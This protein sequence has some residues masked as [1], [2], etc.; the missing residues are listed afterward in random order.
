[1]KTLK[2]ILYLIALFVVIVIAIGVPTMLIQF[3]VAA[4]GIN[5]AEDSLYEISGSGGIAAAAV[6]C[7]VYVKK[8]HSSKIPKADN[9]NVGNALIFMLFTVFFCKITVEE[10]TA[11]LLCGI[12]P[13]ETFSSR[14]TY[15]LDYIFAILFAPIFEELL[16][17]ACS[18]KA[19]VRIF[20]HNFAVF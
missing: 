6:L 13:V 9:F 12:Y 18:H 5:I 19:D 16:F 15:L 3:F 11:G 14:H 4:I 1:M 20:E 7:A 2:N 10:I 8:K 17:R